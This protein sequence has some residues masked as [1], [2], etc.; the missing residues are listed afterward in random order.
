MTDAPRPDV[1]ICIPSHRPRFLPDALAS[2]L[3]Q[4][5]EGAVEILVGDD[6]DGDEVAEIVDRLGRGRVRRL[7]NPRRGELL[8]NRELLV[9][10]AR[11]R[12][13]KFLFNDDVLLGPSLRLLVEAGERTGAG[14]VFH[15]RSIVDE[16]LLR[17]RRQRVLGADGV[18]CTLAPHE[19]CRWM[20]LQLWDFV[21]EPS[22]VLLRRD[23][24]ERLD[25]PF[26]LR[27]HRFW[28]LDDV[29]LYLNLAS[30]GAVATGIGIVG[31][32]FR[33]HS[34][35]VSGTDRPWSSAA[36]FEWEAVVRWSADHGSL[37]QAEAM[38]RLSFIHRSTDDSVLARFPE[39]GPFV[40]CGEVPD[41]RGQFWTASF[42]EALDHASRAI[43]ERLARAARVPPARE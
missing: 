35:Q 12:W 33:R 23:L 40:D 36:S 2:A 28:M 30:L 17:P 39:L 6:T 16:R 43:T 27:G 34:D 24:L 14:L 29:A 13:V 21:G 10:A 31:S 19:L 37:G 22:N 25:C 11:G 15:E 41:E 42:D 38:E 1:S 32:L 20:A 4:D 3:A 26:G 18:V 8:A 9:A 7:V 5:F